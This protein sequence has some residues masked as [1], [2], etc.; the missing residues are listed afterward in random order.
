MMELKPR[1]TCSRVAALLVLLM[2]GSSESYAQD[3]WTEY[4]SEHFRILGDVDF[5][6]ADRIVADL[7]GFVAATEQFFRTIGIRRLPP[8]TLLLLDGKGD[9]RR[10]GIDGDDEYFFVGSDQTFVVLTDLGDRESF[11]ELLHRYFREIADQNV[12]NAP[13]WVREGLAAFYRTTEWSNDRSRLDTGRPI[14]R[15]VRLVRNQRDRLGFARLSAISTESDLE[16]SESV[17]AA[18]SWALMHYL[19][20]RDS[21]RGHDQTADLVRLMASGEPFEDAVDTAFG[22][23]FRQ[24]LAEFDADL[25]G[26]GTLPRITLDTD[27]RVGEMS[28]VGDISEIDAMTALGALMVAGRLPGAETQLGRAIALDRNAPGPYIALAPLLLESDR[29]DEVRYGI[30]QAGRRQDP[31]PLGHYYYA[32]SLIR[33]N[34][35][36]SAIQLSRIRRELQVAIDL[37][38]AFADS[39]H[40]L[41]ASYLETDEGADEALGMLET[42]LALGPDNPDYL[43]T[44]SRFLIQ[45]GRFDDARDVLL[46]LIDR[47]TDSA[48]RDSA[49]GIMES[50][51]GRTGGR[52]LVGE[53]FA[54]ITTNSGPTSEPV[55]E[56]VAPPLAAATR[57]PDT[58]EITRLVEGEQQGGLLTL[59][60][61]RDGLAL[62]VEDETGSRVFYTD[63]PERV[64]FSSS[65]SA[66]VGREISCGIQ[67]PPI[68]VVVTFRPVQE[69]SQFAG[70]PVRVE[71]VED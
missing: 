3:D 63:S 1:S 16:D 25:E 60:D 19:M 32:L 13:L 33:E 64:N 62:T 10:A 68:R 34:P 59:V 31:G 5:D 4:R 36:P 15:Y 20:T 18:E 2:L 9:L 8:A 58:I 14:D 28:L 12:P 22:T 40:Q 29:F 6:E 17:F 38:P 7:E 56:P 35:I 46:P 67:D 23:G 45:Q 24:L 54:E 53:G 66:D 41:A 55:T 57:P 61:C 43:V 52:G 50:I 37:D 51:A 69:D 42:A 49:V 30:D 11:E 71:F 27:P 39:Y 44:Y 47:M 70:V 21:G 48:T 26:R 65:S